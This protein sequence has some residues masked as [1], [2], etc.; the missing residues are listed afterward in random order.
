[1]FFLYSQLYR[2]IFTDNVPYIRK[3]LK[4]FCVFSGSSPASYILAAS[5]SFFMT[6]DT[7][8]KTA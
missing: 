1:M 3:Y 8:S 2:Y 6:Y 4:P 7:T 5:T